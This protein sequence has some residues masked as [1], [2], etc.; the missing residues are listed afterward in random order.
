MNKF[1]LMCKCVRHINLLGILV[2]NLNLQE[3]KFKYDITFYKKCVYVK[4]ITIMYHH[5]HSIVFH[6]KQHL[7]PI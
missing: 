6:M 4:S 3:D 7:Q 2:T 5:S 1:M